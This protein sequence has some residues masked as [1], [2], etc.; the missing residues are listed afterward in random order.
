MP[1]SVA[2][3]AATAPMTRL[4]AS[5]PDSA[6]LP[7]SVAVPFKREALQRKRRLDRIVEGKQRDQQYRQIEKHQIGKHV[8]A[9]PAAAFLCVRARR[10]HVRLPNLR[11]AKRTTSTTA[12]MTSM[13]ATES[14]APNGQSL[15]LPNSAWI[16]V[17]I[18]VLAGPPTM[19][20]VT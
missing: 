13:T 14:A 11:S 7:Y 19:A 9:E 16:S 4:L 20:G 5:A 17:P 3:V 2:P 6:E 18:M 15:A 8:D 12:R 10:A 1:Q